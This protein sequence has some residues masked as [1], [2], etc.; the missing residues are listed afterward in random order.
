MGT[1]GQQ[2]SKVL[3]A[4]TKSHVQQYGVTSFDSEPIGDFQGT[5]G[6]TSLT[7]ATS[8]MEGNGVNSRQVELHQ[9]YYKI[10]RAKT[11]SARKAAEQDLAVLLARRRATDKTFGAIATAAC[12]VFDCVEEEVL[13]GA[14]EAVTHVS[15][16]QGALEAVVKHCGAFSD[17]SLRYSRLL[18]NLCEI[19]MDEQAV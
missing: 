12:H 13:E 17:Y 16:H 18:A 14:V 5:K 11:A 9:A 15:C 7:V 2:F 6:Q 4:V 10:N 19:G 1:V 3:K 8:P